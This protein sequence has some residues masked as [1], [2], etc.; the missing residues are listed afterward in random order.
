MILSPVTA[1]PEGLSAELSFAAPVSRVF[2]YITDLHHMEVWWPEHR[3]YR[4]LHGDGGAGSIYTWIYVFGFLPT[5]GVSRVVAC[6][7]DERFAYQVLLA[8]VPIHMEYRFSRDGE[9]TRATFDMR[10][11]LARLPGFSSMSVPEAS[12]AFERLSR[13]LA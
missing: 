2:S 9:G 10:S 6:D 12:R 11:L 13:E 1:T 8:G 5:L 3:L 7:R 4:R